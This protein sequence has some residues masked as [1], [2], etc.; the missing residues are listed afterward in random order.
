MKRTD[1][2]M[3][4][5]SRREGLPMAPITFIARMTV[6]AGREA[7]FIELCR[8]LT[9]HVHAHESGI[10]IY[11]FHRLREANRFAV[12]ESFASEAAEHAHMSSPKLAEVAPKIAACLIG[13][14]ER[15]YLDPL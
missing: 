12:I 2:T 5:G 6:K 4:A 10:I 8:D 1:A 11:S 7:E 13:T 15:E 3:T 9:E 14:W